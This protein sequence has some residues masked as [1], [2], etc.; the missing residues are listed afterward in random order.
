[1]ALTEFYELYIRIRDLDNN[2]KPI[3]AR[4]FL[5]LKQQMREYMYERRQKG[6]KVDTTNKNVDAQVEQKTAPSTQKEW[7][8]PWE[9]ERIEAKKLQEELH[10]LESEKQK[11]REASIENVFDDIREL[12]NAIQDVDARLQLLAKV[13]QIRSQ[14]DAYKSFTMQDNARVFVIL[15]DF[16]QEIKEQLPTDDRT[17]MPDFLIRFM[18]E[19]QGLFYSFSGEYTYKQRV[20]EKL[21]KYYYDRY[22]STKRTDANFHDEECLT[23][24]LCM[25]KQMCLF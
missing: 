4:N 13:L 21:K 16:V 8:N 15:R 14:Y 1:M 2:L 22:V 19:M 24:K 7:E 11:K 23:S 20:D 25:L 10:K 3:D 17:D 18:N 5:N 12:V 9:K 6:D